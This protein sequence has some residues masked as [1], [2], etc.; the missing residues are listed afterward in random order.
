M[1]GTRAELTVGID[2]G[3]SAHQVCVLDATDHV[4]AERRV[5]HTGTAVRELAAWLTTLR[6]DAMLA[7][8]IETPRHGVIDA[9]LEAGLAVFVIHPRQLERFRERYT[10]AAAK[11]DH[12]DAWVLA[13]ALRT[14]RTA[15]R[16]VPQDSPAVLRLRE[17][18]RLDAELGEELTRLSN[19]LRDH[20][21]RYYP[22]VLELSPAAHDAW[23]CELLRVVPTPAQ[24]A[25]VRPATIARVLARSRITRVSAHDVLHVLRAPA[26]P[27]AAGLTDAI[28]QRVAVLLPHLTLLHAQRRQIA[29]QLTAALDALAATPGQDREHHDV[30]ILR[31]WPGIGIRIA[32]T[33]L[34]EAHDALEARD[35]HAFRTRAGL[36]PVT[37]A[38]G[39]SRHVRMRYACHA[40][41]R[42]A[43]FHWARTAMRADP[44]TRA[45][46]DALRDRGHSH[47]RAL[48]GV[49]DRQVA[50]LMAMLRAGTRYDPTRRRPLP[51]AA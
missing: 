40:R 36:A 10:A 39:K 16:P 27:L 28:A 49:A 2:W 45:A 22:Q 18:S 38:S 21:Q 23:I 1:E 20:L 13:H 3:A 26:L 46:Y 9:L 50:V 25:R 11:D 6:T 35:Y 34:A 14:D 44:H 30:T 7:V 24:A 33:M 12:R 5:A 17:L 31:S 15:Y 4:I 48:R 19:R 42:T 43:C 8:A 47:P 32:A 41:L 29:Q 51:R 37:R